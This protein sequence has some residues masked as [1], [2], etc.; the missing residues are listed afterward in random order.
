[1]R[2]DRTQLVERL[3]VKT[4]LDKEEAE[5][6]LDRWI[7]ETVREAD[8]GKEVQLGSF[9]T[10]RREEETLAFSPSPVL[11]TELNRK[12][13]GL[14]PIE[15]IGSYRRPAAVSDREP[16]GGHVVE[17]DQPDAA[18]PPEKPQPEPE[19]MGD[20]IPAAE[21]VTEPAEAGQMSGD[22]GKYGWIGRDGAA[23]GRSESGEGDRGTGDKPPRK[24]SPKKRRSDPI[25]T[26]LTAAV[27]LLLVLGGGWF[28]YEYGFDQT[29]G[30]TGSAGISGGDRPETG[31][32]PADQDD[33]GTDDSPAA[34]GDEE[35]AEGEEPQEVRSEW[36]L[37]GS[38]S[39]AGGYTIVV[40]SLN[41]ERV[42]RELE[43][44]FLEQGYR[45]IVRRTTVNGTRYWRVG[46]G[47]FETVP[48]A[49]QAVGDL[50]EPYRSEHFIRRIQ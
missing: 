34:S 45:V 21:S 15:L 3:S 40:H 47:E 22:A 1:M 10:F 46:L 14:E 11:E 31:P 37:T 30:S 12:Y 48:D 27:V 4:G 39:G 16:K 20:K 43:E 36:G 33:A 5:N 44:T 17:A 42:A 9:G 18:T 32:P 13:S 2:I 49:Q 25:G 35:D 38:V 7:S 8:E 50:P 24:R 6:R 23:A 41:E 19:E 29:G 28:A 26:F